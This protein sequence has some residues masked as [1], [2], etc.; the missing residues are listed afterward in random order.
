MLALYF[1]QLR[2]TRYNFLNP[3]FSQFYVRNV[4]IFSRL[5]LS[6]WHL[7]DIPS[8]FQ[9]YADKALYKWKK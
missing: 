4:H 3:S 2:K 9:F 5:H 6:D 7:H 1:E 8:M